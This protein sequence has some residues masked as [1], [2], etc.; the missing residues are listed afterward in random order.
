MNIIQKLH[1]LTT[2]KEYDE[3]CIDLQTRLRLHI[4]L[5]KK[6]FVLLIGDFL[7]TCI[8]FQ[9]NL[10]IFFTQVLLHFLEMNR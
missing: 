6:N 9:P 1:V 3:I 7:C 5:Q 8:H 4:H 2:S 10:A